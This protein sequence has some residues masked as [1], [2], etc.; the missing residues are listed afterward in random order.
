MFLKE[1]QVTLLELLQLFI[2][3]NYKD[4]WENFREIVCFGIMALNEF[5]LS[6]V[7][8]LLVN[9]ISQIFFG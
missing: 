4:G 5:L 3:N 8:D 1:S 2:V 9:G 6:N 7:I